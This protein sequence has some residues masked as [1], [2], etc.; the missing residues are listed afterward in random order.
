MRHREQMTYR[1]SS[2]V[3]IHNCIYEQEV[4]RHSCSFWYHVIIRNTVVYYAKNHFCTWDLQH[5]LTMSKMRTIL[6]GPT[7]K[8]LL[9]FTVI[10]DV[11]VSFIPNKTTFTHNCLTQ[12]WNLLRKTEPGK[13][14][15]P[16]GHS[17]CKY[18]QDRTNFHRSR[19]HGKLS[20]CYTA[21]MH[22]S[23]WTDTW[24]I[25][26]QIRIFRPWWGH[27]IAQ[28]ILKTNWVESY[29]FVRKC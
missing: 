8:L 10:S 11:Y 22:V 16:G 26:L 13:F 2:S 28:T 9:S 18:L 12:L 25:A 15:G 23:Q 19:G 27:C 20:Q 3:G 21:L 17:K 4:L 7:L 29:I 14:L 5:N 6:T 24:Y 1:K